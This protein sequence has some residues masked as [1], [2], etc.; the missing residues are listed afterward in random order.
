MPTVYLG[1]HCCNAVLVDTLDAIAI[2]ASRADTTAQQLKL[3]DVARKV[4]AAVHATA[5]GPL[6]HALRTLPTVHEGVA[7]LHAA[8]S[9]LP[10][11][12]TDVVAMTRAAILIGDSFAVSCAEVKRATRR[13]KRQNQRRRQRP[14]NAVAMPPPATRPE[15]VE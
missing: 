2:A 3:L 7:T 10:T 4:V 14:G 12:P 9:E 5:Y 13:R 15:W 8:D 11:K 6:K 1:P